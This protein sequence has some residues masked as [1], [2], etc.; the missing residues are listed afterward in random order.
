MVLDCCR[1]GMGLDLNS[2]LE[3]ERCRVRRKRWL[4][5]S[6]S[7]VPKRSK[8]CGILFVRATSARWWF[9]TARARWSPPSRSTRAWP[10]CSWRRC[11]R[12]SVL[13]S[14]SPVTAPSR[15]RRRSN[16]PRRS[17]GF[18][19]LAGPPARRFF[20]NPHFSFVTI[21]LDKRNRFAIIP[22]RK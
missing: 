14:Q 19:R 20:Y 18:C 21:I 2:G 11:C 15:L 16:D 8:R 1:L 9:A 10:V 5:K 22:V 12:R 4:R 6:R 7:G 13:W 17:S 3:R